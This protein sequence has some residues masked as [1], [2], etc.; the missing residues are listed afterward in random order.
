MKVFVKTRKYWFDGNGGGKELLSINI[1]WVSGCRGGNQWIFPAQT[2]N[3]VSV[4]R[5][6]YQKQQEC[7]F[8]GSSMSKNQRVGWN[9]ISSNSMCYFW[10]WNKWFCRND[11]GFFFGW[12]RVR[13]FHY[14]KNFFANF[15]HEMYVETKVAGKTL[16]TRWF[17]RGFKFLYELRFYANS[18]FNSERLILGTILV[19]LNAFSDS[20]IIFIKAENVFAFSVTFQ[21][22][23]YT[24]LFHC[25]KLKIE[26]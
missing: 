11:L 2:S 18:I 26:I 16:I 23:H 6:S 24:K 5:A 7:R 4:S 15:L 17:N 22:F 3:S 20:Q 14:S 9:S 12:T 21:K 8:T 25:L 13:E 1:G 10:Q 19:L